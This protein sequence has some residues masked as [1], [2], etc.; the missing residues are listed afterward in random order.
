MIW[1]LILIQITNDSIRSIAL[2]L[3]LEVLDMV[4]CPLIDDAGLQFLENGSPSL[5]V[6]TLLSSHTMVLSIQ[7]SILKM[8][9]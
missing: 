8:F 7:D 4:S 1:F 2:L 3:K 6:I 5:Q 9:T